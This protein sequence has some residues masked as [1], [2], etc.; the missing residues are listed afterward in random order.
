MRNTQ[1]RADSTPIVSL[2]RHY[3]KP[4]NLSKYT[5]EERLCVYLLNNC[6]K[7]AEQSALLYLFFTTQTSAFLPDISQAYSVH[8]P[9][10]PYTLS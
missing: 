2:K 10:F 9:R 3:Q 1:L 6:H 7:K 5:H 4:N 8:T